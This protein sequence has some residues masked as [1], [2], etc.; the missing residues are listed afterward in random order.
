MGTPQRISLSKLRVGIMATLAMIIAGTLIF[1]LTGKG[2]LFQRTFEAVTFMDDSSGM[3]EGAP[4]RLNGIPAGSIDRLE[5]SNSKDPQR[6]VR[7]VMTIP[8]DM[9]VQIP[10]DSTARISASNLLGD[11]FI[12]ITKGSSPNPVKPG[13]EI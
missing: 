1:L 12:N 5:L 2:N 6:V 9:R 8:E 7:I 10:D 13:A 4:V 3:S 11:K